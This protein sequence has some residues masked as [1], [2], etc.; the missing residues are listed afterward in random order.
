MNSE[1]L[2]KTIAYEA[3]FGQKRW[4]GDP[5]I[6][7]PER[8]VQKFTVPLDKALAWLHD[9]VEDTDHTFQ[10]IEDA[11]GSEIGPGI[12]YY[13]NLLT[14]KKDE[15]YAQY[16]S[17]VATEHR[18]TMI[19]LADLEDNLSD[20]KPGPRRDKYELAQLFLKEKLK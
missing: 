12:V 9:V 13:L 20:L 17:R 7:H 6:T 8:I 15:S 5:Y 10:S 14:H 1:R 18:S 16:I 19:K 3:H 4:N 11:F 2:A